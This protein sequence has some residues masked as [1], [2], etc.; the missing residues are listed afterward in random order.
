MPCIPLELVI[1]ILENAYHN[2]DGSPDLKTLGSCA[3]VCKAWAPIAQRISFHHAHVDRKKLLTP[4]NEERTRLSA[5]IGCLIKRPVLGAYVRVLE[6][7]LGRDRHFTTLPRRLIS[8]PDFIT[9]LSFCPQLYQLMLSL[10]HRKF[11]AP[12]LS[13]LSKTA[14]RLQALDIGTTSD[15]YRDLSFVLYQL[16]EIWPS[17]RFL[18][19]RSG[20]SV[21]PPPTRPPFALY[22]LHLVSPIVPT[23]LKWLLPCPALTG[24]SLRVLDLGA[25]FTHLQPEELATFAAH[26]PFV[27]SLRVT[28]EPVT[29]FVGLFTNIQEV[30]LC[31]LLLFP[32]LPAF[33]RSVRHL[34]LY[35]HPVSYASDLDAQLGA[36]ADSLKN[37][38]VLESV[39]INSTIAKICACRQLI[40]GCR[41]R[42]VRLVVDPRERHDKPVST[43]L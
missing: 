22:E 37:L 1:H 10:E 20:L 28:R 2:L 14:L 21:P 30:V 5:A 19:L 27:Y 41:G 24:S 39:T 12:T 42:G 34:G 32:R 29:G 25:A 33:P 9:L 15:P 43:F 36:A 13:A 8:L 18:R 38:P 35:S 31:Q 3:L 7:S 26:A 17:I 6:V 40:L 16:M 23:A 4:G 11:E